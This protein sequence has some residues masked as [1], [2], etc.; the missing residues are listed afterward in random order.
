MSWFGFLGLPQ[1]YPPHPSPPTTNVSYASCFLLSELVLPPGW[2]FSP[3]FSCPL[4]SYSRG[5]AESDVLHFLRPPAYELHAR[6]M[7]SCQGVKNA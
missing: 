6:P 3:V 5:A 2:V 7:W 1:A 4:H